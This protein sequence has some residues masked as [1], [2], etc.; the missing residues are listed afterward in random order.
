MS[1]RS[2]RMGR[3]INT[4]STFLNRIALGSMAYSA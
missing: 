4:R 3:S 2:K 1:L